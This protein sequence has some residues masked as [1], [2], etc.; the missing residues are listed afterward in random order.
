MKIAIGADHRGFAFKAYIKQYVCGNGDPIVWIDAGADTDERSDFPVFTKNVCELILS[1][2]VDRGILICG[3]GIGMSIAAN[4]H[5][6]IYGALVWNKEA[7]QVSKEHNN[8]NVLILPAD[9]IS[10]EQAAQMAN[11]WLT[12]IFKKGRYQER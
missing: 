11:S 9:F 8:A 10:V 2:E 5:P 12:A 7:A 4:R 1:G 3:S 6:K